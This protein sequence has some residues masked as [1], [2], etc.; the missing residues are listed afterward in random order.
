MGQMAVSLGPIQCRFVGSADL[1]Y[2]QT[3]RTGVVRGE[4]QDQLSQTRLS[5]QADFAVLPDGAAGSVLSLTVAYTLRG[6]LAQ[7]AKGPVVQAF[8]DE[9]AGMVGRNV[10]ARLTGGAVPQ[11]APSMSVMRLLGLVVWNRVK[12]LLFHRRHV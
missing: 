2:D 11:A 9:I 4:G 10:Q 3:A 12:A 8:A 5:A 7:L 6:A 1:V